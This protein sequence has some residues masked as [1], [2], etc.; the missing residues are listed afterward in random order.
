MKEGEGEENKK[1]KKDE[2][3]GLEGDIKEKMEIV[4][5]LFIAGVNFKT[6]GGMLSLLSRLEEEGLNLPVNVMF[7]VKGSIETNL[8]INDHI[9]IHNFASQVVFL[10][11]FR[12]ELWKPLEMLNK[13]DYSIQMHP[14][15]QRY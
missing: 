2:E 5:I 7:K 4:K 15:S 11:N 14:Y 3:G 8:V 13:A 6:E 10:A 1:E 9:I 12:E